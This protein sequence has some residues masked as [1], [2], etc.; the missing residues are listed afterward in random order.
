VLPRIAQC[1]I[2]DREEKV[3]FPRDDDDG[4]LDRTERERVMKNG[5][6]GFDIGYHLSTRCSSLKK[7]PVNLG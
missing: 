5:G 2:I 3:F 4:S 7:N 1:K 6:V